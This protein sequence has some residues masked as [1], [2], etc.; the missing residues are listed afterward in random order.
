MSVLYRDTQLNFVFIAN[1]ASH[2][3][4]EIQNDSNVGVSFYDSKTTSWAS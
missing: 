3:F 4:D 1:N 2:K